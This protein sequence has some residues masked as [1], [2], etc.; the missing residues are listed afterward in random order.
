MNVTNLPP[1]LDE[2]KLH[3]WEVKTINL[4]D[5]F[6]FGA[7][8]DLFEASKNKK[9]E[10]K[11]GEKGLVI[12]FSDAEPKVREGCLSSETAKKILQKR[13][14]SLSNDLWDCLCL[15]G[16]KERLVMSLADILTPMVGMP[17]NETE[18]ELRRL[19]PE[20]TFFKKDN[21]VYIL[22]E[23]IDSERRIVLY[24]KAIERTKGEKKTLEQSY[25]EV[26]IHEFFHGLHYVLSGHSEEMSERNDYT[27]KVVKESL[28]AW[29]EAYYCEDNE[30][31]TDIRLDWRDHPISS[32]PYSGAR[33]I[34]DYLDFYKIM[35]LSFTDMD[36]ALRMLL[37]ND[38]P[39]FYAVKNH[40]EIAGR[41][42]EDASAQDDPSLDLDFEDIYIEG[43]IT[44]ML[45]AALKE[46]KENKTP[47]CPARTVYGPSGFGKTAITK[48]WLKHYNLKHVYLDASLLRI[49]EEEGETLRAYNLKEGAY[50][51]DPD[52]F[53]AMLTPEKKTFKTIL[54][55]SI[56]DQL[57]RDTILVIDNYDLAPQEVR[58]ELL[59]LLM[60]NHVTDV[61]ATSNTKIRQ[62]DPLLIIV[63]IEEINV[64]VN[65]VLS[66]LEMELFHIEE[67]EVQ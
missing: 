21:A 64:I 33:Y 56:I 41:A 45:D 11:E 9:K 15:E 44:K 8:A 26:F 65:H 66:P 30:I 47:Y 23:Y 36:G 10:E 18:A 54:D 42:D 40:K 5:S 52:T 3:F 4:L 34:V 22:G 59:Q 19:L 1:F 24:N 32:Y 16:D 63:I 38:M 57:N 49:K 7:L 20:G 53:K 35:K 25:E 31:P 67:E 14:P 48:S 6:A 28:A 46:A 12:E 13:W 58:D 39:S 37:G 60:H 50:S 55:P 61:R 51:F 43:P 29:F 27:A 62:V 17:R 2:G